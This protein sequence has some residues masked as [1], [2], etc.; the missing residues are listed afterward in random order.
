MPT[1]VSLF[2]GCGGSDAGL[3]KAGFSVLMAND[4]LP[5]ARDVYLANHDLTDYQLCDVAQIRS[6]PAADLLVGCY[7]CQGFS[8]GGVREPGRGINRLYLEFAR[9]LR[10][11]KP[12][13]FVVENVSGMVR[14][15]YKHLLKNQLAAFRRAGYNV[16]CNV[17]SAADHG[18]AQERRR[19][20]IVGTRKDLD[21]KYE[22]PQPTH[23]LDAPLPYVTI[24]D[25][26]GDMPVWPE[27]EFYGRDFHWYYLSRDRRRGWDELSKT[28]VANA[29]HMPLHPSSPAL[30]KLEHNVWRFVDDS[31][32]RRFSYREAAR[33]QG[34]GDLVFPD[35][36]RG[37]LDMRYTVVGN[38]VPPPLFHA[39]V[40][41]LLP[42]F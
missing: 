37:S 5:Y 18:V 23:G 25:A 29:R 2:S 31:P 7:P 14:A 3:I 16:S 17:L 30:V 34:F 27:G 42:I 26:I 8:Q 33:L 36:K 13:A 40:S 21:F 4:V 38:A 39:V 19:I 1:A 24:R 11:I 28:I 15:N 12:K 41:G 35:A 32:A 6:F 10:T 22:F 20:F 9:A